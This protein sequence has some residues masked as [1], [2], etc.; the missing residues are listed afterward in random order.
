[1]SVVPLTRRNVEEQIMLNLKAL[2][3]DTDK[4]EIKVGIVGGQL[5]EKSAKK[6]KEEPQEIAYYAAQNEFGTQSEPRIP[7]RP[8]LRTTMTRYKNEINI[9]MAKILKEFCNQ[10]KNASFFMNK[11][12]LLVAGYVQ[13]NIKDGNWI[14]NSFYTILRKSKNAY[15]DKP[16]RD[17]GAMWQHITSW[18]VKK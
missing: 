2:L 9:G 7:S 6:Y 15:S 17:T 4:H 13:L 11:L 16:L 14:P 18:T 10:N 1:M 12:G 8:F 3:V 5:N